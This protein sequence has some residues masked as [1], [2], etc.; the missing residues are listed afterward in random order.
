[1]K[2]WL[3]TWVIGL[4]LLLVSIAQAQPQQDPGAFIDQLT[5]T[6]WKKLEANREIFKQDH[7]ALKAFAE[8]EVLPHVAVAKMA[9]YVMGRHWRSATPQQQQRF[10]KAFQDM[11]LRSYANT[12]LHLQ[13]QAMQVEKVVPG[14]RGRYSVEQK[15]RR[16]DGTDAKVVYRVYWDKDANAWKIYDVVAENISLLLNYRKVFNSELQKM[17]IDEVIEEM[18]IKNRAFLEQSDAQSAQDHGQ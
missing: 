16:A 9:K 5:H 13:I 14:Q 17:G 10:V 18:E 11:L 1:M 15:V 3:K 8:K 4:G 2:N 6:L 12:L 7:R